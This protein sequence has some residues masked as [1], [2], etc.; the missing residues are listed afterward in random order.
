MGKGFFNEQEVSKNLLKIRKHYTNE[1]FI[2]IHLKIISKAVENQPKL[3]SNVPQFLF[4]S[5]CFLCRKKIPLK[6]KTKKLHKAIS[7]QNIICT[8]RS[9]IVLEKI[10]LLAKNHNDT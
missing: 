5:H 3:Y 2:D 8:V 9:L 10:K 4:Q 1:K 7:K 6:F